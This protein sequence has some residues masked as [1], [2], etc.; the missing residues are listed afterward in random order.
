MNL[1]VDFLGG[2][3]FV[4]GAGRRSVTIGPIDPTAQ[5]I[6]GVHEFVL[7][8]VGGIVDDGATTLGAAS[9]P[10][11]K[12][13]WDLTGC[14]I[15]FLPGGRSLPP[16]S[17]EAPVDEAV[18]PSVGPGA[19]WENWARVPDLAALH[20]GHRLA[21]NWRE[22]LNG[23]ITLTS[24]RIVP[25]RGLYN[26]EV[27]HAGTAAVLGERSWAVDAQWGVEV[28]VAFLDIAVSGRLNGRIRVEPTA[29][30]LIAL[31]VGSPSDMLALPGEIHDFQMYYALLDPPVPANDRI[32]MY[33]HGQQ[34][35]MLR[36]GPICIPGQFSE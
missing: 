34:I 27:R 29:A 31:S 18:G 14:E 3:A 22:R 11:D 25:Y 21:A 17:L 30:G 10:S 32:Q 23:L 5:P 9:P 33:W 15:Q 19:G 12:P 7:T 26:V 16:T 24:G 4:F 35:L 1:K 2:Y 13:S 20:P 6:P 28:D 36:P 8:L